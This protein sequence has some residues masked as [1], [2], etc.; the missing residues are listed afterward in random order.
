MTQKL[1]IAECVVLHKLWLIIVQ[2]HHVYEVQ[3]NIPGETITSC[4]VTYKKE[5]QQSIT[6]HYNVWGEEQWQPQNKP[7]HCMKKI[8]NITLYYDEKNNDMNKPTQTFTS[9]NEKKKKKKA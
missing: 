1:K 8:Q 2:I 5:K 6:N 7:L 4:A 9:Y 3:V